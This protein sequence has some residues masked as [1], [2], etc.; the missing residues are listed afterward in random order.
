MVVVVAVLGA[1]VLSVAELET[2]TLVKP[3][4]LALHA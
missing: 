4:V 2:V 3:L 1:V